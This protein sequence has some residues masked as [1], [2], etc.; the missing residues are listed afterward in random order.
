[1]R[2]RY[3]LTT[4]IYYV[5]DVPHIG[6]SYTTVAADILARYRRMRGYEVLLATGT[7]ENAT[8]VVE[9]AER[10]GLP[11]AQFVDQMAERFREAWRQL[12]IRYDVFIRT[13]EERHHRAVQHFFAAQRERGDIYEGDYEGW[14]CVNCETFFTADEAPEQAG[15]RSCPNEPLHP[16]LQLVRERNYFFALSRYAAP[17]RE[18][19]LAH[20]GFLQPEFRRNE[21]LAFIDQGLRDVCITRRG[22]HWGIPVPGDPAQVIYVWF[23]AL[24]NYL[25]VAGYPDD[26]ARLEHWWPADVH[27]VGKDIYVRF[28]CTL[29]PAM[30]MAA[31]LPLPGT[32][33]GHGFWL[34]EGRKMS[35]SLGNFIEPLRL[36]EWLAELSGTRPEIA[37]DAI[38]YFLFREMPFGEDGN[39]ARAS[40]LA[41]FNGDLANDLG[42]V[43]NRSL[44]LARQNFGAEVPVPAGTESALREAAPAA[45]RSI[46]SALDRMDFQAALAACWDYIGAINRYLDERAPWSLARAGQREELADVLYQALEAARCVTVW[47][48]PFMPRAAVEMRRQLGLPADSEP[49]WEEAAQ[50]GLLRPAGQ[51]PAPA[52]IFPRIERK[53]MESA[54]LP[55]PPDAAPRAVPAEPPGPST[56]AT[57]APETISID[58]FARLDLRIA[59][60]LTAERVP[61]SDKLLHLRV[62]LGSEERTVL[63]GIAENYCPEALVGRRVVIIANLAPR[64]MRGL[65]S[66]GMLLAAENAETVA[67]LQPD[68]DVPAGTRVR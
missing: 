26:T 17:L 40:L 29:W 18:H 21:V 64:K 48:A 54:L 49:A 28:H 5:N 68:Q 61:K 33:F 44:S 19:I 32:V 13:S 57:P 67:L 41:R 16:P 59:E 42:N 47:I 56:E 51:L 15:A 1:M 3:Y 58:D 39:F 52:P 45:G 11:P 30:L 14:Y 62:S 43:L 27:L 22:A 65:V 38:R 12:G 35:K 66:Q 60:V 6:T 63:A 53:R 10:A 2:Q 31:G 24:I 25:T 4:P 36:A 46:A 23:D 37:V 9:A 50:W 20:P 55:Q 7:D 34:S 8:K